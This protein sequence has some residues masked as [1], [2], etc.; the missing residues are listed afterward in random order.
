[1]K[2][3]SFQ[4]HVSNVTR[5]MTDLLLA[6]INGRGDPRQVTYG[7]PAG[8]LHLETA[9][10]ILAGTPCSPPL[11]EG[12]MRSAAAL[13]GADVVLA[14]HGFCP[15][16]LNPL[17]FSVLVHLDGEPEMLTGMI[18]YRHP[19]GEFWLV[20][21]ELGPCVALESSGLK[22]DSEPPYLTFHQRC[23]GISCAAAAVL[24]AMKAE[25]L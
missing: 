11:F 5:R 14:H 2:V 18:L 7:L 9:R 20:P 21:G 19:T 25:A 23:E 24:Q 12:Q 15:E 4:T 17:T 8:A 22:L 6:A 1:M 13:T 3:L 10:L 16:V